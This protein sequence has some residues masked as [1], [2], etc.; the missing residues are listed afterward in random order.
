MSIGECREC[1]GKVSSEA[2]VCPHCGAPVTPQAVKSAVPETPE[3]PWG[4]LGWF[5]GGLVVVG[6]IW[7]GMQSDERSDEIAKSRRV[8]RLCWDEQSKKSLEPSASR[9]IAG[10][11]EKLEQDFSLA[12]GRKP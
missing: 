6:A 7:A 10:A 3:S 2:S 5:F 8:I 12:Y 4:M 11:C 1:G 9:M